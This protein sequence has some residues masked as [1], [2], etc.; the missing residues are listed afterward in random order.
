MSQSSFL[1][2]SLALIAV[3]LQSLPPIAVY[4]KSLPPT[5]ALF[6]KIIGESVGKTL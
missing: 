6:L 1:H 2:Q 3:L 4:L 5:T